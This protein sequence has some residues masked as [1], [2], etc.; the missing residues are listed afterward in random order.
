MS[1][2]FAVARP[3]NACAK[4]VIHGPGSR[5]V[6]AAAYSQLRPQIGCPVGSGRNTLGTAN[7]RHL[8]SVATKMIRCSGEQG[9][10]RCHRRMRLVTPKGTAADPGYTWSCSGCSAGQKPYVSGESEL[11]ARQREHA[12]RKK[13]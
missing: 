13:K 7:L 5:R 6:E 4:P 2:S 8:R 1:R 3:L 12:A 9:G 10:V 11:K